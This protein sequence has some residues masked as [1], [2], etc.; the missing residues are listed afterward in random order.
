MSGFVRTDAWLLLALLYVGEPAD[1]AAIIETGDFINH[2]IF[3]DEELEGGLRRLLA[4]GYAVE[5]GGRTGPGP[6]VLTWFAQA[7]RVS[8]HA[9]DEA[10]VSDHLRQV[11][12]FLGVEGHPD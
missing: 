4:A 7:R 8:A 3:T 6:S 12:R 11:E 10:R 5:Q 9:W 1:R 2:A